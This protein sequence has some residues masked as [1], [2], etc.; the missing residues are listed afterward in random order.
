[1]QIKCADCECLPQ[2][3]K[4]SKSPRECPYCNLKFEEEGCCCWASINTS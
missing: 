1:M 2:E 4:T 3:C